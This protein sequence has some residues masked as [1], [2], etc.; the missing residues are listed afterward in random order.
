MSDNRESKRLIIITGPQGSGNHLFSKIFNMHPDVN[1]WDFGERYWI[2]SDEEPFAEAWVNPEKTKD[3][4]THDLMVANV[5]VPFVYDGVK[6]VPKIQQVIHEA[7][8][9]GYVVQVCVVVRD[10]N[11]NALQQ[12][13]VRNAVT[14]PTAMEYYRTLECDMNFVSHE[15]LYLHKNMYLR[16]L[17]RILDFP[18]DSENPILYDI[19]LEDQNN[20]YVRYVEEHWLDAEVWKG[21]RPKK[22]RK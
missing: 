1:G 18:I 19:L 7:E 11:I 15:S 14:L 12:E 17:S 6:Q 16:W 4:L 22:E 5:S 13:R 21:L 8:D 10:R 20:K 3:F 9:A 2:P